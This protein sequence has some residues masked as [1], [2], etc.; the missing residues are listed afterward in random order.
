MSPELSEQLFA[1]IRS[2]RYLKEDKTDVRIYDEWVMETT[3]SIV[4]EDYSK[5][6]DAIEWEGRSRD[7]LVEKVK[8]EIEEVTQYPVA[9][10]CCR[11]CGK[12]WIVEFPAE[13]HRKRRRIGP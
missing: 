1:E 8:Y 3:K 4:R 10:N 11:F 2:K 13:V 12:T 5:K 7:H 6:S 9:D